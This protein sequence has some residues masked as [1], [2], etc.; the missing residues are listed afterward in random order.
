MGA[1]LDRDLLYE[2][3]SDMHMQDCDRTQI[4]NCKVCPLSPSMSALGLVGLHS[5]MCMTMTAL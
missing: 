1:L 4:V 5:R 2:T 3:S